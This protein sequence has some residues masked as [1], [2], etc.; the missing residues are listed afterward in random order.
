MSSQLV[1]GP[2]RV[3]ALIVAIALLGGVL[4]YAGGAGGSDVKVLETKVAVTVRVQCKKYEKKV[5][6]CT[7]D[8]SAAVE[9][10]LEMRLLLGYT[11]V[12]I[13]DLVYDV[14]PIPGAEVKFVPEA[15]GS[16]VDVAGTREIKL[17]VIYVE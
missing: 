6:S 1:R 4:V 16:R 15:E 13:D 12:E 11:S 14:S 17:G 3:S 8:P 2:G 7:V 9:K 10:N 5:L